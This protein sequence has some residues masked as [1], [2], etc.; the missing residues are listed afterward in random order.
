VDLPCLAIETATEQTSIALGR[1]SVVALREIRGLKAPS[2]TVYVIIQE[3]LDELGLKPGDLGLLAF[4]AGPGSFTGSR[5][6]ASV[7]QALAAGL[8]LPVY[9]TSTLAILAA[10]AHRVR[11]AGGQPVRIAACLD[12]RMG[13]LYFGDYE[14]TPE[15]RVRALMADR[16]LDPEALTPA[17]CAGALGAGPGWAAWRERIPAA[18]F[19]A[20]ADL[21]AT[22]LPSAADLLVLAADAAAAGQLQS[23][24][25]ALPEYLRESVATPRPLAAAA[26]NP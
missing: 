12:A 11:G 9:R 21:D 6:A 19:T 14:V 24:A 15:G 3:L 2:R 8:D 7:C 10:T 17:D 5:V 25:E 22:L 1:G 13:Q 16:V 18:C 26:G 20:L 23:A 4:G